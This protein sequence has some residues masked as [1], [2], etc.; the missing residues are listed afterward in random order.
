M[1]KIELPYSAETEKAVIACMLI[2]H[3]AAVY[4][5][6]SVT[7]TAFYVGEYRRIYTAIKGLIDTGSATDIILVAAKME[8][9]GEN[10]IVPKLA[11]IMS[12][13]STSVNISKYIAILR[14]KEYRRKSIACAEKIRNAAMQGS[15]EDINKAFDGQEDNIIKDTNILPVTAYLEEA[16]KDVWKNKKEGK[17]F[18]GLQTK[19]LDLDLMTG[20]LQD[21]DLIIIAGRPAMGKTAFALEIFRNVAKQLKDMQKIGLFF[22]LEMSGKQIGLRMFSAAL[23]INNEKFR[24]GTLKNEDLQK[25]NAGAAEFEADMTNMYFCDDMD[26]TVNGIYSACYGKRAETRMPV[27]LIVIDYL[28]LIETAG[29]NR[30]SELSA[31][32]RGL[33]KLA[34]SFQCPVVA[35]SQLSRGVEGRQEKRPELADLRE[36]GSIEQDADMVIFLYRE[37]YYNPETENKNVAEVIIKKQRNGEVGTINLLFE[38]QTTSFKNLARR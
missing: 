26:Y 11:E 14:E 8:K 2:D 16:L 18:T 25:I 29:Q 1:A 33:K 37:D 22:S 28:Q 3:E 23:G 20:G 9:S 12:S 19:F 6:N 32:T 15:V 24:F 7:E 34:K 38:P 30:V 13:E 5:C 35:L 4:A 31:I 27:G 17:K 10:D 36:S 21:T